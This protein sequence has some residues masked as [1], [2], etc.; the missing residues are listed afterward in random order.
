[1]INVT[2]VV[3]PTGGLE[4]RLMKCW[5]SRSN[6]CKW[7]ASVHLMNESIIHS[8]FRPVWSS[9]TPE[10]NIWVFNS[11]VFIII[12]ICLLLGDDTAQH[13]T[14]TFKYTNKTLIPTSWMNWAVVFKRTEPACLLPAHNNYWYLFALTQFTWL[15]K[16]QK[17]RFSTLNSSYRL[18]Y[19]H[20]N[21]GF[22]LKWRCY[23]SSSPP[24]LMLSPSPVCSHV[25]IFP[26]PCPTGPLKMKEVHRAD[27][28]N[29]RSHLLPLRLPAQKHSQWQQWAPHGT[30]RKQKDG[31]QSS[32]ASSLN[33]DKCVSLC[34]S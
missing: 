8:H 29:S 27:M 34:W 28:F 5:M 32:G 25:Y 14:F 2:V 18:F 4:I 15:L 6:V 33:S 13:N 17:L 1:M 3:K 7:W 21:F 23:F 20:L 24:R 11:I 10:G 31:T 26:D 19:P 16:T 12:F 22:F 30:V 9:T